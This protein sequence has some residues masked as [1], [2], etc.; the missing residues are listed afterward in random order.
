MDSF[1]QAIARA[2]ARSVEPDVTVGTVLAGGYEL[3]ERLGVG[4]MATVWRAHDRNLGRDV[5]IKIPRLEHV[6]E[7]GRAHLLRMFAREARTTAGLAHPNII[8]LHHVGDHDG[9]PFLVLE[10]LQGETLAARLD[11]RTQLSLAEA[12]EILDGVLAALAYAHDRGAIHRDLTPRNVFLTID[13]RIKVLD[14]GVATS[15]TGAIGAVT[16]S[17]GTP[18]YMPPEAVDR[19]AIDARSDLWSAAVV[20][21]ECV[22]GRRAVDATPDLGQVPELPAPVRDVVRRALSRDP[23]ARP[24]TAGAMRA[25]LVPSVV[26]PRR[27]RRGA[28]LLATTLVVLAGAA[29]WAAR[30]TDEAPH[31]IAPHVG[32]WD[33]DPRGDSPWEH[34]LQQLDDVHYHYQ[35]HNRAD[36]TGWGGTLTLERVSDGS[37]MLRGLLADDPT[38]PTCRKVGMIE[39]IVLDEDH[40]YQNKGAWGWSHDHYL[41]W[42]PPYRY[43]FGGP[44]ATAA[45]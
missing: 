19:T 24:S 20:F 43:R 14:F 31:T 45:R 41:E 30:R 33:P 2:P 15:T 21:L 26:A 3:R 5:A 13:Q 23:A 11:R 39:F 12:M 8:T 32:R 40:L 38:C 9:V 1:I 7:E 34:T 44:V 6:T 28:V 16:R 36:G 17:A 4:G 37:T 22:T 18:G 27:S 35:T 29:T 10:L 42:F 25:A